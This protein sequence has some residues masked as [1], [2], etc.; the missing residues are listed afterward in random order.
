MLK[1]L[2]RKQMM[3]IFR[4]YF[5]DPKK[6]Q[7]RSGGAI[8]GYLVLFIGLMV[9]VLGGMFTLLSLTLCS[10]LAGT[11]A[12]WTY[13]SI[14]SLLAIFLGT[15]GSVF[16]TYAGLY[17]AKDNDLLLS[18][19][20]PVSTILCARLLGVYLTGL[21][22]SG[23]VMVPAVIV[24]WCS[25]S[26][27]LG[28]FLGGV[29]LFAVVSLLVLV[30]SCV[31][32]W[33]VAKISLRLKRKSFLA[34]LV[35]L[36]FFGGYYF[37]YFRAQSILSD[38][39]ANMDAYARKIHAAAYP[40]YLLG[41]AGEGSAPAMLWILLGTAAVLALTW[42]LLSKSFLGIA[43]ASDK[44]VGKKQPLRGSTREN[45]AFAALLHKE[46]ARFTSSA[47]YMLNCGMGCLFLVV[48][49]VLFVVKGSSL[50][51]VIREI[52]GAQAVPVVLCGGICMAASMN[53]MVTPSVSLEA[54]TL[55]L[56]QTLPVTPWQI[57][58]AKLMMQILLTGVPAALCFICAAAAG[59]L[60]PVQLAASVLAVAAFIVFS[61]AIGLLFGLKMPN[62]TWTSELVPIKQGLSVF[63][64]LLCG[65]VYGLALMG[66]YVPLGKSFGPEWYLLSAFAL[67]AALAFYFLHWLRKKG[68]A[69]FA[70]LS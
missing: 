23:V 62:F 4:S 50:A 26:F 43:T 55:W 59:L 21:M 28:T 49:G 5:Y 44:S 70:M 25:C 38:F 53:D 20:I 24:Y 16:N 17:L 2:L 13:F 36:L 9:I 47:N 46:L 68:S 41:R 10:A 27:T 58:R 57:L 54:H 6:N 69:I 12:S 48:L 30:L 7:K 3:E 60:S 42:Y 65:W 14:L 31:L 32:G 37:F 63:L 19:P 34:V 35:S 61:A 45:S 66:L 18:M 39:L 52:L 56:L 51:N 64:S 15:F 40:L 33:V 8:A 22:Y 67:T 11:Q 29:L 1:T